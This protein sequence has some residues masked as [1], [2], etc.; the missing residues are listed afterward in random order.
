[1][2]S[3]IP[4]KSSPSK[5]K[6][7]RDKDKEKK[8]RALSQAAP[9]ERLKTV[10]RRLPPNLPEEIFWQSVQTWVTDGTVIWKTYY[11]GKFRKRLNKENIPSRAYIAFKTEE[12]VAEFGQ[13][14][15]GHVFKDKAGTESQ[16]VVEFAPYQKVPTE[17]KKPD[18]RVGTIEKDEDYISFIE[19]LNAAN[20][21]ELVSVE[22]LVASAQPVPQPKTTALLEAL[23]AEKNA[24]KEKEIIP[25]IQIK[26]PINGRNDSKK[27]GGPQ[28]QKPVETPKKGASKAPPA[29]APT[30]NANQK[31]APKGA[32]PSSNA[33]AKAPK[34]PRARN[35]PAQQPPKVPATL[36]TSVP[37]SVG[38]SSPSTSTAQPPPS[39]A[40][41]ARRTRPIVG[42][43]SRQFE[44]A[45]NG[46]GV[47]PGERRPRR[48]EKEKE[49]GASKEP[50]EQREVK[51]RPISPKKE[52]G[53][54]RGA[55]A[56]GGEASVKVP[57]ILKRD[58]PKAT[59][60]NINGNEGAGG[61]PVIVNKLEK[62][63]PS[64]DSHSLP[65]SVMPNIVLGRGGGRRGRGRGRVFTGMRGG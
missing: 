5:N 22:A 38:A 24:V 10:V 37:L 51:E 39:P 64:N 58:S 20:N 50:A 61:N 16:A 1:M 41:A 21:A 17:K 45:L 44:A 9:T 65:A 31:N 54:R 53:G 29:A 15:D 26:E 28:N 7:N 2:S 13:R 12:Q 4:A 49:A 35:Q 32:A 46:A 33:P 40:A 48:G 62:S 11:P 36:N 57:S 14:F 25:R 18:A 47:A 56:N 43:A 6:K 34:A 8:E 60:L 23:K 27:K 42:L 3:V 63:N 30:A 59:T 52:R 19:S 55:P